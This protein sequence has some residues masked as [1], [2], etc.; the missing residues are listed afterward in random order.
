MRSTITAPLLSIG[1]ISILAQ[2]VILRELNVALYGVELVYLLALGL[3]LLWTAAGAVAGGV[4]RSPSRR[5]MAVLFIL[6]GL[7]LPGDIVF[8]RGSRILFGG[9]PGTY[10]SFFQQL[11]VASLSLLPAGFLS[12]VLFQWTARIY[13]EPNRTLAAAYAV[14]S[15]GGLIGGLLSTLFLYFGLA[16]IGIAL[17]CS[18]VAA[19]T[20]LALTSRQPSVLGKARKPVFLKLTSVLLACAN[21]ALL[22]QSPTLDRRLNLWNHPN[23]LESADS[24]YGRITMTRLHGQV[25]VFE[26]D[27]L[28]F[29]TEGTEAESFCHLAALQH[30]NPREILV[31]GGGI[32]GLVREALK[33]RPQRIDYIELNPVLLDLVTRHLPQDIGTSLKAPNVMI[34]VADPRQYLRTSGTYDLILV[35]MPEPASGQANR[36]YTREFFAQC[37]TKLKPGGILAF[38]LRT[39]ENL[40]PLPLV[41]RNASIYHALQAV[42]PHVL[43]LPGTTNVV[44]A[45]PAALPGTPEV[46]SGRLQERRIV[47]R[48][49][50][51]NYIRYLFT[52]DRFA[53]IRALL[54]KGT[55]PPNTDIRPVCYQYAFVIW[56]SKFFPG[57]TWADPSAIIDKGLFHSPFAW[58]AGL[59]LPVIFLLSRL[60]PGF[61][62]LFLV[63]VSGFLGMVA[64]T[65]LILY[66]QVKYG[67]LYRDIGLLLMSFMAGLA[68]GA[69]AMNRLM[70]RPFGRPKKPRRYGA[71]AL[72]GFALLCAYL[73]WTVSGSAAAGLV[74]TSVLLFSAGFLVAAIFSY[75]ALHEIEDQTRII[76]PL[77]AADLAGGCAGSLM[78]SL[79]LIPLIGMDTSA[80]GMLFL[81]VL[82]LLLI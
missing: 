64:E 12:G 34:T 11:A 19:L 65:V 21:I 31:L 22:W 74:H 71:A 55:A 69:L 44:T 50:S 59:A 32:E 15:A 33:H 39:A 73:A 82:S 37:A 27:A 58:L 2:I 77:Y 36:F 38:R 47:T 78:A 30:P 5:D 56:L 54:Q 70:D 4:V 51:A 48:L 68:L 14:E 76:A 45:S 3:W 29:E 80:T 23:L 9:I 67:V 79:V 26:N 41:R 62:R 53:A 43:F 46:M 57:L 49:V 40:W 8:I 20:P 75:A 24:P 28:A 81:A 35:G 13:I 52:N 7:L 61:R 17:V 16:N 60:R 6:F 18:L 42:F 72:A 25:S 63:A 10:L 1:L 66:Y